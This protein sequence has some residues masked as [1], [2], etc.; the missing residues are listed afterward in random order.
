MNM[1]TGMRRLRFSGARISPAMA[2]TRESGASS[3][4]TYPAFFDFERWSIPDDSG[5]EEY[6]W[7]KKFRGGSM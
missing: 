1:D 7:R 3:P 6:S 5:R 4:R 2:V